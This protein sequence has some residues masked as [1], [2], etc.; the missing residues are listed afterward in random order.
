MIQPGTQHYRVSAGN[1]KMG[2]VEEL[3]DIRPDFWRACL[4]VSVALVTL[5]GSTDNSLVDI[6]LFGEAAEEWNSQRGQLNEAISQLQD[7][8]PRS[9]A[10]FAAKLRVFNE[11][12]QLLGEDDPRIIG[13]A[14]TLLREVSPYF[15]WGLSNPVNGRSIRQSRPS[16]RM[17]RL[18][19]PLSPPDF[20]GLLSWSRRSQD[21]E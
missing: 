13:W 9:T 12:Q 20:S 19:I 17:S 2:K 16:V 10:E 15:Q 14:F 4:A 5:S 21:P 1:G 8:R 3:P 6:D 11:A 18:P 7:F